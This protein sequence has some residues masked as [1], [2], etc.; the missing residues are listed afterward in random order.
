MLVMFIAPHLCAIV[1]RTSITVN[2]CCSCAGSSRLIK[3]NHQPGFCPTNLHTPSQMCVSSSAVLR[4]SLRILVMATQQPLLTL[5]TPTAALSR[6][7]QYKARH[8]LASIFLLLH[9]HLFFPLPI[10]FMPPQDSSARMLS[11][12]R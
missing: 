5:I 2:T 12:E 11:A 7:G 8:E 10:S 9:P 4:L 1:T 6:D 3:S